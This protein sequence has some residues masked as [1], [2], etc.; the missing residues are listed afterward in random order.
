MTHT[1]TR[2]PTIKYTVESFIIASLLSL[3]GW[4]LL[5]YIDLISLDNLLIL[6]SFVFGWALLINWLMVLERKKI[7]G[8]VSIYFWMTFIFIQIGY[9]IIFFASQNQ[10]LISKLYLGFEVTP[11][12]EPII[13]SF[14]SMIAFLFGVTVNKYFIKGRVRKR[15]TF[16]WPVDGKRIDMIASLILISCFIFYMVAAWSR[17]GLL[18]FKLMQGDATVHDTRLE[19]HYG[20]PTYFFFHP[21]IVSQTYNAIGPL[22]LFYFIQRAWGKG[23]KSKVYKMLS[24]IYALILLFM[25]INSL[26]RSS[27]MLVGIWGL[28]LLYYYRNKV[29]VYF[30]FLLFIVFVGFSLFLHG[31]DDNFFEIFML[32]VMRRFFIVNSMVNY[33]DYSVFP[34][35]YDFRLGGTYLAYLK[36]IGGYGVSFAKENISLIYPHH[37]VGTA[38]VGD[39]TEGWINFGWTSLPMFVIGGMILSTIDRN[40]TRLH[41][42]DLGRAYAAGVVMLVGSVSFGGI[43]P[44]MFSG[45]GLC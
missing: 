12:I 9:L 20:A 29:S 22:I 13:F 18:T 15:T 4:F 36:S 6:F 37:T 19:Y 32:N 42:N 45:G 43:L 10:H 8:V 24:I 1:L 39:V 7:F 2:R 3:S 28:I 26:H 41:S 14:L 25:L 44:I 38:P 5:Y 27:L 31:Y 16:I 30:I 33:F 40:L 21:S 23:I 35:E 34:I 11:I 17:G